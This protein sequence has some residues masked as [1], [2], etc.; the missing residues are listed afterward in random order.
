MA[1]PHSGPGAGSAVERL[2]VE[3]SLFDEV[4]RPPFYLQPL[5]GLGK[6]SVLW[7]I[8]VTLEFFK[9]TAPGRCSAQF[10][11]L[12]AAQAAVVVVASS[13]AIWQARGWAAGVLS[14]WFRSC[15]QGFLATGN[16]AGRARGALRRC[17]CCAGRPHPAARAGSHVRSAGQ[18]GCADA[19]C[20]HHRRNVRPRC[21]ARL[22]SP[23]LDQR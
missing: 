8:L 19:W 3:R 14:G 12:Y 10:G 18:N 17:C 5:W 1:E 16:R 7:L 22:Y 15:C 11:G 20:G 6:L 23:V 21:G 2:G 13:L 9:S 4:Q